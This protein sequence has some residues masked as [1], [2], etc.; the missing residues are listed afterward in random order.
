L[1]VV[2][3]GQDGVGKS[4]LTVRLLTKRFI[5]EYDS[6]LESAYRH[7][8]MLDPEIIPLDVLDTAGRVGTPDREAR[9]ESSDIF[10][11]LY[12]VTDRK[13]F[14]EAERI[15]KKIRGARTVT[16]ESS[17]LLVGTKTDLEHLREVKTKD[18][19]HTA[20]HVNCRFYEISIS[21][22][23]TETMDMFRDAIR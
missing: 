1:R 10:V 11:I 20:K 5:G 21:E 3:L 16:D 6:T 13:S 19:W 17:V 9:G 7:H 14:N 12:S 15:V 23:Y 4:A 18:G 2:V 22:G 8:F